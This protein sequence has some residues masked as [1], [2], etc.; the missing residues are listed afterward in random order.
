[1]FA[2]PTKTLPQVDKNVTNS[3]VVLDE[4]ESSLFAASIQLSGD[5]SDFNLKIRLTNYGIGIWR[6]FA[7]K[8]CLYSR[9]F[10]FNGLNSLSRHQIQ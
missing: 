6:N 1:M 4:F 10:Q 7:M 2:Y 5:I 9:L 3:S 8:V